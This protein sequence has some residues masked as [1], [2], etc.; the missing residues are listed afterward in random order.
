MSSSSAWRCG[1]SG[2]SATATVSPS[3]NGLSRTQAGPSFR[4]CL[5][6]WTL[7]EYTVFDVAAGGT[8][9]L[10]KT[11]Y[12]VSVNAKN[13]APVNRSIWG[14][15]EDKGPFTG[16]GMVEW[17]FGLPEAPKTNTPPVGTDDPHD[18]VRVLP[19]AHDQTHPPSTI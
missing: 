1:P 5:P 18:K 16:S 17:S 7:S 13:L 19:E 12:R 4:P 3:A 8:F 10:G 6:S 15:P 11:R 2:D 14:I 9:Q